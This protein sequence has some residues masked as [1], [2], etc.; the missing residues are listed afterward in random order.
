VDE[1]TQVATKVF[2]DEILLDMAPQEIGRFL[3]LY[4]RSQVLN[5]DR[6]HNPNNLYQGHIW[7]VKCNSVASASEEAVKLKMMNVIAP[8]RPKTQVPLSSAL[9]PLPKLISAP[10]GIVSYEQ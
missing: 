5:N 8:S 6:A 4:Y 3:S 9:P 2:A 10:K 7:M 1:K